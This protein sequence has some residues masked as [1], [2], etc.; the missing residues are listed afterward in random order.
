MCP[1]FLSMGC[2]LLFA[3]EAGFGTVK[4]VEAGGPSLYGLQSYFQS[5]QSKRLK[6]ILEYIVT[7]DQ[8]Y[9]TREVDDIL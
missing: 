2:P 9:C 1:S 4:E 6:G 8:I 5:S 7:L 3:K